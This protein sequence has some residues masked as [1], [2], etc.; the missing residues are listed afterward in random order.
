MPALTTPDQQR[1]LVERVVWLCT[2]RPDGSPHLTPVWFCYLDDSW[3]VSSASRNAK[4]ANLEHDPRVSLVL[5][6]G[7]RPV[8]AEGLAEL[9]RDNYPS[10]VTAG[11]ADKYGGWDITDRVTEGTRV[12]IRVQ[13]L[14]W[15]MTG[16]TA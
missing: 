4:V 6:D 14:R 2:L 3:W 16:D 15:L 12:L 7:D 1:L 9:H 10:A 5:P 13:V 11:F 8:V